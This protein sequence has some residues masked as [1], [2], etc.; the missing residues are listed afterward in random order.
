MFFYDLVQN[1]LAFVD[2][3]HADDCTIIKIQATV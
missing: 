1:I 3:N 2:Y